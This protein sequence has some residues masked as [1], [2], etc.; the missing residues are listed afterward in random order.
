MSTRR[1]YFDD[2]YATSFKARVVS[3]VQRGAASEVVLDRTLFY[4]EGGGQPADHGLLGG[5]RVVD[6][7]ED[8]GVIRHSLE[9]ASPAVGDEVEGT[10]DFARRFDHMQQHSGQHLLSALFLEQLGARTVS[11]HLGRERAT[12][13]LELESLSDADVLRLEE[14]A[15]AII[16]AGRAVSPTLHDDASTVEPGRRPP[17]DVVG[18]L[19]VITIEGVDACPC[20]GTH[21]RTTADIEALALLGHDRVKGGRLRAEFVCGGRVRRDHRRRLDTTR[22]LVRTLSVEEGELVPAGERLVARAREAEKETRA[23]KAEL[24]PARVEA[25]VR[26]APRHGS[27]ALVVTEADGADRGAL[28]S[29]ATALERRGDVAAL[30]VAPAGA[31]LAVVCVTP[32]EAGHDATAILREL[33][34]AHGGA[35][36]GGPT[37][38]QGGVPDP[39]VREALLAAGRAVFAG[40]LDE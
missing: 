40:R 1:L 35:G 17:P 8:A 10:V 2:A 13:D 14:A 37:L 4:P 33:L 19:R 31:K 27:Y 5:A 20:G 23:L 36:G 29:L 38:A 12:I 26:E 15:A 22:R 3:T 39:S 7:Q 18:P 25:L 34:A 24:L 16:R 28:T 6:V 32:R 30:L 9:G 11:F 21:V